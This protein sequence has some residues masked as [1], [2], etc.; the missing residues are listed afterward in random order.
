MDNLAVRR[1]NCVYMD[2]NF[3]GVHDRLQC[4]GN[5]ISED[6]YMVGDMDFNF[7]GVHDRLQCYY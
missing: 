3:D 4:Y 1:G 7:D 2:F 6:Q 5:G